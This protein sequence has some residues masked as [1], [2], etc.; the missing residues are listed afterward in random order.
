MG[1]ISRGWWLLEDVAEHLL[2]GDGVQRGVREARPGQDPG[3]GAFELAD[4]VGDRDGDELHDVVGDRHGLLLGLLV[5]DREAGLEV[6]RLDVGR[7][8]PLE[9]AAQP[10]LERRDRVG[11][12][13]RRDHDLLV[14]A[15]EG[16]ERVEELLLEPFLALHELDVVD[17]QHVDLAVAAL[18]RRTRVR[19]DRVDE[20]VQEDLG[21]DIPHLVVGVV[22]L[23]VVADRVEQ[24]GLAEPGRPVDEQRVVR[25]CR[26]LGDG[27]GSRMGEA[28][29]RPRDERLE[30]VARVQIGRS[31][32][33]ASVRA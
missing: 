22:L 20:L 3:Q 4:V 5:E 6:G 30:L 33:A 16:V 2:G 8:P 28:V 12:A 15:V 23:D 31:A 32:S 7:E 21:R 24:V 11:L 17:H 9:P 18:E 10:I 26:R 13:V 25:P 14:G 1:V 19:T 29:R 27:E